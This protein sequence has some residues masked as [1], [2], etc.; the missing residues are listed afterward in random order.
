MVFH[1]S[2]IGIDGFSDGFSIIDDGDSMVF[3]RWTIG[4]DGFLPLNHWYQ[5]FFQW[6]LTVETKH[7]SSPAFRR[8]QTLR[9]L[10]WGVWSN[11]QDKNQTGSQS[12]QTT[13]APNIQ[14]QNLFIYVARP[15]V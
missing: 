11:Q 14:H 1:M 10:V 9:R 12:L 5:W 6:F 3:Y 2:T 8:R 15:L 7:H 13:H 4:I